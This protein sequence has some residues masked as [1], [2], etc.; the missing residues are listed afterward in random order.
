ML[1][2]VHYAFVHLKQR[3]EVHITMV[4]INLRKNKL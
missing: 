3:W 2:G 1:Y 4:C